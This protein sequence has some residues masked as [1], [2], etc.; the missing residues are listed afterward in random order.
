[1]V[2][3]LRSGVQIR[4][5]VEEFSTQRTP[6]GSE[7]RGL[8]WKCDGT[9]DELNWVDLNEV[10]AVHAERDPAG[11]SGMAVHHKDGDPGNSDLGNLELRPMPDGGQRG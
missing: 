4:M 5:G 7:L 3:T 6:I 11:L 2:I 8:K 1:M 10:V 9:G